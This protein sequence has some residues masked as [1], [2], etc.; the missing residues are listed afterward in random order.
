MPEQRTTGREG[1]EGGRERRGMQKARML[2]GRSVVAADAIYL[3][4]AE[5]LSCRLALLALFHEPIHLWLYAAARLTRIQDRRPPSGS[6][7]MHM[8]EAAPSMP[9]LGNCDMEEPQLSTHKMKW[10]LC[11]RLESSLT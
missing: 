4:A 10:A 11:R 2:W 3:S 9:V 6:G 1:R 5:G 8:Q 7:F